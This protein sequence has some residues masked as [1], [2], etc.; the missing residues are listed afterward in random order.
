MSF[1]FG[2]PSFVLS[3]G[4]LGGAGRHCVLTWV[5]P[6]LGVPSPACVLTW[7]CPHLGEWMCPHLGTRNPGRLPSRTLQPPKGQRIPVVTWPWARPVCS[8]LRPPG[9]SGPSS[10]GQHPGSGPVH[11]RLH[12]RPI[13]KARTVRSGKP[14]A[15]MP[16][17]LPGGGSQDAPSVRGRR[18]AWTPGPSPGLA[19]RSSRAR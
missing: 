12:L 19:P 3:G 1:T 7:V 13:T 5:C 18:E 16:A 14:W 11:P 9:S 6:H 2:L 17:P 8:R 4:S 10:P 15:Q